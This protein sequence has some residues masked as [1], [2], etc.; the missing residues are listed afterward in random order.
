MR[1]KLLRKMIIEVLAKNPTGRTGIVLWGQARKS[2]AG[3]TLQE[4]DGVLTQLRIDGI[5]SCT[6]KRW[7]LTDSSRKDYA[8]IV[9]E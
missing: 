1:I 4:F 6:N 9:N 5:V 8:K 3:Y 2:S 7:W